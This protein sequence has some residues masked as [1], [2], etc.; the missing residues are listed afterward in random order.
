[1]WQQISTVCPG[2][3]IEPVL[4]LECENLVRDHLR[5][6]SV[7]PAAARVAD[8]ATRTPCVVVAD[9]TPVSPARPPPNP[10]FLLPY[11]GVL[12]PLP[13]LPPR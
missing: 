12:T 4:V 9:V 5:T 7:T 10:V 6:P 13:L 1:M 8:V 3:T 2:E 11:P